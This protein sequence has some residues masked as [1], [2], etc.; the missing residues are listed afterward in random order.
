MIA[1]PVLMSYMKSRL[2]DFMLGFPSFLP[3]EKL[4]NTIAAT[5][6]TIIDSIQSGFCVI[7]TSFWKSK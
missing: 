4:A 6:Y 5:N 2:T 7:G 3:C 1:R